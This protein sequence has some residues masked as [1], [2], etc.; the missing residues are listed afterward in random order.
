M[1]EGD[2][3]DLDGPN[4]GRRDIFDWFYVLSR[5]LVLFSVV[6]S[7]SSLGRFALIAAVAVVVYFYKFAQQG[8][9]QNQNNQQQNNNNNNQAAAQGK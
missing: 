9:Q 2:E 7:Y 1:E 8:Q 6:Y 3:D 5:V 4:G